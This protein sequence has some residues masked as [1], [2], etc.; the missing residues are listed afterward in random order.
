MAKRKGTYFASQLFGEYLADQFFFKVY[1]GELKPPVFDQRM[2][3]G[4][5]MVTLLHEYTHYLH[6]IS[7]HVGIVGLAYGVAIRAAL[8]KYVSKDLFISDFELDGIGSDETKIRLI[9][10]SLN[11]I[12]G[13]SFE[14]IEGNIQEI[15]GIRT[16]KG[17]LHVPDGDE[18]VRFEVEMPILIVEDQGRKKELSFGKFFIYEGLAYELEIVFAANNGISHSNSLI[19]TEYTILRYLGEYLKP[20]IDRK[21]LLTLASYSLAFDNCGFMFMTLVNALILDCEKG[22]NEGRFLEHIRPKIVDEYVRFAESLTGLLD[23]V[24]LAYANRSS[25]E[26]TFSHLRNNYINAAK[27]RT[28]NPAFEIDFIYEN[29]IEELMEL[30]PP[31]DYMIVYNDNETF[32]RDFVGTTR[33]ELSNGIEL[34]K[35][36]Q[37]FACHIHYSNILYYLATNS[38]TGDMTDREHRSCP[39]Y[40]SC[41]LKFRVET[42]SYCEE[43]PWVVYNLGIQDGNNHCPYGIGVLLTKGIDRMPPNGIPQI[44]L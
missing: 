26:V 12:M 36:Y 14:K 25:L 30:I 24:V 35:D 32:M 7:T 10:S 3:Q 38:F 42:P 17:M 5:H 41:D 20:D 23:E 15:C 4:K 11:I 40:T 16:K 29:K 8:S 44:Q 34:A 6:E 19:G 1:T 43:V 9:D 21:T 18:F 28:V 33:S 39:Y 22:S 13:D 2:F 27:A 37:A 31:C